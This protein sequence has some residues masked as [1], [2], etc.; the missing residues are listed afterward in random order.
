MPLALLHVG[1]AVSWTAWHLEPDIVAGLLI[2]SGAYLWAL[3]YVPGRV[4]W[5]RPAS[6]YGGLVFVFLAL[7]SP[8]DA[9]AGWLLSVHMLQ[10]IILTTFGPPLILLGL[11]QGVLRHFFPRSQGF[12]GAFRAL[13]SPF[14]AGVIFILNMW[15]WHVPPVYEAALQHQTVHEVMHGAFLS[16]GLIFW[17]PIIAPLP[18]LSTAGG[19]ARLLYIFVT[20]FPMG[21][22]ALL[23][24]S[25]QGILYSFYEN[26]PSRL[27]GVDAL[28]DQQVAGVIMG[29]VGE[30]ASFIAFS[31]IFIRF[32]LT[33]EPDSVSSQPAILPDRS[34]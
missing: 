31:L 5:W 33:D 24:I 14:V 12:V 20:G 19:G 22:L 25:S 11:P 10:H 4:E 34:P 8:L 30:V 23:L 9:A 32:F 1:R 18:E 6:F 7:T 13:T 3:R 2:V 21:V 15:F 29:S 16:T 28:S 17:W 26:L 27:W